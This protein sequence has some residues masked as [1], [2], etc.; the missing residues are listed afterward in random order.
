MALRV[1]SDGTNDKGIHTIDDLT[2]FLQSC[3]DL[4]MPGTAELSG[5][6]KITG[7][8]RRCTEAIP[9]RSRGAL[10]PTGTR[11]GGSADHTHAC[12]ARRPAAEYL[13]HH[14]DL[15]SRRHALASTPDRCSG[16]TSV[17]S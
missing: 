14:S 17:S 4:G 8:G 1:S 16:S 15:R 9:G 5:K 6:T 10:P 7:N 12:C 13:A 3:R 2:A 11:F